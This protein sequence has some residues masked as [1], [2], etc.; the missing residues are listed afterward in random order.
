MVRKGVAMAAMALALAACSSN[1]AS[2]D[3]LYTSY[4]DQPAVK[5]HAGATVQAAESGKAAA[6]SSAK[7]NKGAIT[8]VGLQYSD[9]SGRTCLPL[10]QHVTMGGEASSRDVTACKAADST[11]VVTDYAP[12]KAD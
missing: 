4:F 11:W 1:G 3:Q 2:H 10:K 8:P 9:R 7:G 12:E 5:K 6:W